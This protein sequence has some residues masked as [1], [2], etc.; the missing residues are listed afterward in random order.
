MGEGAGLLVIEELVGCGTSADA[1][2]MTA[3][4][5]DGSGA[6]RAMQQALRQAG[7]EAVAVQ[8]LNAP[9]TLNL[10]TPNADAEGLDLIRG[11][12]RRWP[13]EHA[14]SNGFGCGG[15]NASVLFRRRV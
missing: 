7:V 6:R 1:Y 2:H 8:Y 14:L 4:P 11:Q 15:V 13:M 12:A 3:G 10:E 9:A 5:E